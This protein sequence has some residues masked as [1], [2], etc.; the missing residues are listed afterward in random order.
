[1]GE[2]YRRQAELCRK[3]AAEAPND[4]LAAQW[5]WMAREYEWLAQAFDA[6]LAKT[7]LSWH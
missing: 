2:Y 3:R 6:L 7:D 1:M 5:E 4:G